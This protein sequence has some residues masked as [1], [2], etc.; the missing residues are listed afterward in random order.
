MKR[1]SLL[2]ILSLVLTIS[3]RKH[4]EY[5]EVTPEMARDTLYDIMEDYYYWFDQM[6]SV[7]KEDYSN[8]YD[9]LDAMIYKPV[10][11]WSFVADYDEFSD[12]MEGT[13]T[14]H[15]IR[16]GLGED[17]KARVAQIYKRAPLYLQGVR[18]G[19]IIKTVNGYDLAAIL[20]ANDNEAYDLA[21]GP[22]EAGH[23]NNF[24]FENPNGEEV[25]ISS[26]KATFTINSVIL[27]D[28]INLDAAGTKK[29]GHL[30]LES[31]IEPTEAELKTAFAFL[32]ASNVKDLILDLR[33]NSGGYLDIA[34]HL[35]SY[36]AGSSLNGKKFCTLKFNS[37]WQD[38]NEVY[39]F[40]NLSN[41]LSLSRVVIITSRLTASASEAVINGLDPFINV[42]TVGDTT[43][44]KPVGMNGWPCG[45][46]YYFWPITFKLFNSLNFGDYFDGFL[47]DQLA[48]DDVTRDFDN[49][50]EKCLMEA[51]QYL[52]TGS[53]SGKGNESFSRSSQFSEKPA[54]AENAFIHR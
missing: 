37:K 16:V 23:I 15:G 17:K 48:T 51:I 32:K 25:N 43:H 8:P 34:C 44:G 6:P 24:V 18:R 26:A 22:S 46:K 30:V 50:N 54:W 19:W 7:A 5:V 4:K 11:R 45:F 9:L 13:F 40:V 21:F 10:D 29:A 20:L 1:T 41:S 2:L 52:K 33:Y 31:F 35:S 36:I 27:Y 14:G 28:T 38:V 39:K 53:F 12:E 47:P 49:R 42:V 3:C